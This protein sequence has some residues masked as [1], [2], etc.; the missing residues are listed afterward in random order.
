MH[1]HIS[2][3]LLF[4]DFF[5]MEITKCERLIIPSFLLFKNKVKTRCMR[6]VRLLP[7]ALSIVFTFTGIA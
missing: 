6:I 4:S 3:S 7:I 2:S 5:F 1:I